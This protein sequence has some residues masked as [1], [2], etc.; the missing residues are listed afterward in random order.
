MIVDQVNYYEPDIIG[1]Q[2]GED[3]MINWLDEQLDLYSHVGIGRDG[4]TGEDAGE[5]T[6]IFFN[7]EKLNLVEEGTFWLSET[8]DKV[9]KGWD[10][11]LNRICTYVLL[12]IV[13]SG[14]RI[15]VFNAHFDHRGIIA[16]GKSAELIIS[17]I[18]EINSGNYPYL[19]MGDLNL[20]PDTKPV[21]LLSKEM[22]DSRSSCISKPFGPFETTNDKFD[23]GKKFKKRIDY[24]FTSKKDFIVSKY[25]NIVDVMD[26]RYPSDHFPVL[27]DINLV[28]N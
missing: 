15:F 16:R 10:A 5:Y 19:F 28:N 3:H 21:R 8:P 27:V 4:G 1:T 18:R 25:A 7:S 13:S 9:S 12:E 14:R 24:I 26:L 22:N 20:T 23:A 11:A 6:A 17:K 2:E